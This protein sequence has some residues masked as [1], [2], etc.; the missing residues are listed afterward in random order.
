MPPVVVPEGLYE[1]YVF[2]L[3]GTIYLGDELLPGAKRLILKLRELGKKV[4]FLSN[5]PKETPICS[6]RR[7]RRTGPSTDR[8]PDTAAHVGG[9]RLDRGR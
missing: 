5:N 4:V 8:P 6:P 7:P 3:D 1:G 2:D 9:V